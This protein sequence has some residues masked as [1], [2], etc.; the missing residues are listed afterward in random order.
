MTVTTVALPDGAELNCLV[1]DYRWPWEDEVPVFM[2]HGFGRNAHF[3]DCWVP[4]VADRRRVYRPEIR[5][6]GDSPVPPKDFEFE[7]AN[8]ATDLLHVM[9]SLGLERVHWVGEHS[10]SLLGMMVALTEP[11]RVASLVLCDAPTH[12]PRRIHNDVYP[13]GEPSTAAA[14]EKYGVAQWCAKTI[15]YRL[16]T[17]HAD[18]RLVAWYVEQMGRTPV[19]VAAGLTNCF[20]RVSIADR[21]EEV[22]APT[23]LLI[24]GASGWVAE[25]QLAS[26]AR[27][28]NART[29]VFDDYGHGANLLAP[30]RCVTEALTFWRSLDSPE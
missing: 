11:S 26:A 13:M 18:P 24:G 23:L 3:W 5:G 2:V 1:D 30:D 19:H 17:R 20:G 9:D 28:R 12:I 6:C 27:L 14:L 7:A 4:R 22:A 29:V 21:I 10:G 8:L 16:D 25:Q 15:D